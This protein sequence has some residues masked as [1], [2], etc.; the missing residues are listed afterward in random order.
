MPSNLAGA[1]LLREPA[2]MSAMLELR[3]TTSADL[4]F[5]ALAQQLDAD[6]HDRY[7]DDQDAYDEH[8][9][10]SSTDSVVLAF[11]DD[12]PVGCGAFRRLDG[13]DIEL[14]RMFVATSH[15]GRGIAGSVLTALEVWAR[16]EGFRH[17][18][19]E[20]GVRQSEAITLYRRAGYRVIDNYGPFTGMPLS[21]CFAKTLMADRIRP[22]S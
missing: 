2:T 6:L 1:H 22:L 12:R 14:K 20:T 5:R 16:E 21:M 15:R 8:N 7:G 19:L 10:L 18:V 9:V 13:C 11:D 4:D 17:A 3:R